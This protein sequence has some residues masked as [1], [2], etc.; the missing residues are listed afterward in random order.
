MFISLSLSQLKNLTY[1]A[2]VEKAAESEICTVY[3]YNCLYCYAKT[4][5]ISRKPGLQLSTTL[6][7]RII[8][9][10]VIKLDCM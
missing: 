9:H 1:K 4:G 8:I 7:I 3:T 5:S 10:L 6:S 2:K